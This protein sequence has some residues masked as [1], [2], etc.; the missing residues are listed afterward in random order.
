[1]SIKI[2]RR[3]LAEHTAS[4]IIAGT[5][6]AVDELAAYLVESRRTSEADLLVRDIEDHLAAL[7]TV[8]VT[9]VSAEALSEKARRDVEQLVL[10]QYPDATVRLRERVDPSLIGGIIIRTPREELDASIR[11][12]LTRLKASN[13]KEN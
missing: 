2:S 13:M 3:K 4:R 12:A 6:G 9:A 1:M 5:P 8:I 10:E 11:T 7:G